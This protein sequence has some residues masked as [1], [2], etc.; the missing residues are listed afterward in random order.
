MLRLAV[1]FSLAFASMP[2]VGF[3]ADLDGDGDSDLR[4]FSRF[5]LAFTGPGPTSSPSEADLN[6]D[7]RVDLSD[8]RIFFGG[9]EDGDVTMRPAPGERTQSLGRTLLWLLFMLALYVCFQQ[10]DRD[11]TTRA[12]SAAHPFR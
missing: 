2:R 12:P 9:L 11:G 8:Y 4:D 3:A 10:A 6:L 7:G 5:Q 1:A